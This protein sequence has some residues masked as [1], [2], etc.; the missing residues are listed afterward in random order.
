MNLPVW[1]E[2]FVPSG[3]T[4]EEP[5]GRIDVIFL[6][7]ETHENIA[8]PEDG[9]SGRSPLGSPK[10]PNPI[11]YAPS[12]THKQIVLLVLVEVCDLV[13]FALYHRKITA[14]LRFRAL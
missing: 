6:L 7:P 9:T 12:I 2:C 5:S 13:E 3:N 1:A 11:F 8:V 14:K 10:P 4:G